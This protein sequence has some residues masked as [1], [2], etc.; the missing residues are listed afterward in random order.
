MER[1]GFLPPVFKL[2]RVL[3]REYVV[4]F[5]LAARFGGSQT[6]HMRRSFASSGANSLYLKVVNIEKTEILAYHLG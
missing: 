3:V 6:F 5:F 2:P 4:V 1:K